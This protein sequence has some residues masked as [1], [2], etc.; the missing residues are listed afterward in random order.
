MISGRPALTPVILRRRKAPPSFMLAAFLAAICY[1]LSSIFAH[2]NARLVGASR[3]NFARLWTAT[4]FLTFWAFRFGGGLRGAGLNTFI[5]SGILGFG[6][7]DLAMYATLPRLGPRLTTLMVQCLAAPFAAL[8]EWLWL[9]T[10]LDGVQLGCG[11]TILVGVALAVAPEKRAGESSALANAT[12]PGHRLGLFTGC[13]AAL[14]QAGGAVVSR[15]AHA[16]SAAGGFPVDGGTAAFQR[17]LGGLLVVNLAFFFSRSGPS[18]VAPRWKEASPWI[19][20]NALIGAV[21]GVSLYQRALSTT[22]SAVVLPIVSLTPL[23]VVPFAFFI[24]HERPTARS[25]VGGVLAVVAA[26]LL[27]PQPVGGQA[28]GNPVALTSILG[29]GSSRM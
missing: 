22:P 28:G 13:L 19:V 16:L 3:A 1:A 6:L 10:R 18:A 24:E 29:L 14:G 4:L 21:V 20:A 7:S 25:L 17:I 26:A 5:F 23:I 27:A 15:K 11:A 2:R 12:L 8:I 9:G